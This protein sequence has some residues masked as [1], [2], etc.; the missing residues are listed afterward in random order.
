MDTLC[1]MNIGQCG[2]VP[3]NLGDPQYAIRLIV[4]ST[5][6]FGPSVAYWQAKGNKTEVWG[7]Y[8]ALLPWRMSGLY[9]ALYEARIVIRTSYNSSCFSPK[10]VRTRYKLTSAFEALSIRELLWSGRPDSTGMR[11]LEGSHPTVG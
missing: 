10:C 6:E 5:F 7:V 9:T 3:T 1:N 2:M 4:R 8:P 11:N